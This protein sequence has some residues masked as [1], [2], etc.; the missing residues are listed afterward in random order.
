MF[1]WTCRR[2]AIAIIVSASSTIA[3]PTGMWVDVPFVRQ[4]HEGCGAASVAMVM[5]YWVAHGSRLDPERADVSVIQ[6]LLYSPKDHGITTSA[7]ERYFQESG[8][9][10]FVFE[11]Q[12]SDLHEQLARGRPLIVCLRESR[13]GPLH[14]VVVDGLDERES[15]TLMNDPAQRKLLKVRRADFEKGWRASGFWTLLAIPQ[16]VP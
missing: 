2:L 11:G 10:T 3:T 9:R 7:I 4:P 8:F 6:R 12:W 14:Y 1:A 16:T 15:L 5:Q 13:R